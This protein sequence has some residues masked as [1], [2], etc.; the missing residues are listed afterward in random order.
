MK[1]RSTR[2]LRFLAPVALA[3][4]LVG[5]SG[6]RVEAQ[7]ARDTGAAD[8][9]AQPPVATGA[10]KATG[11]RLTT[12][13]GTGAERKYTATVFDSNGLA[14]R[15][16]DLDL[17]GLEADPD[18]RVP[19][20]PMTPTADGSG[21]TAT[22]TFPADGD[23]VLV[24]RVHEPSQVVELFTEKIVGAGAAPSHE[25]RANTPSRKAVRAIDPTFYQ[26]YDPSKST[27]GTLTHAQLASVSTEHGHSATLTGT[28]VENHRFEA[29]D[30]LVALVHTT[31]A[32]AWI[33]A[34]LGLVLANRIGHATAR[35]EITRFIASHYSVLAIGGLV[36]VTVT[37]IQTVLTSSAGL[38]HP[39]ELLSTGLGT[40]YLAV[41]GF[42]MAAVAGSV[43]TSI[44][45]KRLLPS[46]PQ[47]A[48]QFRLAS[49][50]AMV[51]DDVSTHDHANL[52]YRLAETNAVFGVTIIGCV[53]IL[54]QLHHA[55]H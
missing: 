44:R 27:T 35:L 42:K 18:L 53:A 10:V 48:A 52:I 31:G 25:E 21:Y 11:V 16:A 39:T 7:A 51:N 20:T 36:L 54:A 34:V 37:G 12:G 23:W 4:F 9:A 33:F 26:R 5:V 43:L 14:V 22:V 47:F 3:A 50:G 24:V 32:A 17:G 29:A 55:L 40:A 45:I 41:F 28:A 19:T 13:E 2:V 49:A 38:N 8:I 15:N 30:A 1:N 6:S 46:Q